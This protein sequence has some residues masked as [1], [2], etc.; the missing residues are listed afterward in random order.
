MPNLRSTYL[1]RA[2][3]ENA[4]HAWPP[5]HSAPR[6]RP[7]QREVQLALKLLAPRGPG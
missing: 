1:G 3:A 6:G 5:Q 7:H 2:R 4:M